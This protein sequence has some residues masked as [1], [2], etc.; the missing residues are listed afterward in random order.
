MGNRAV[1]RINVHEDKSK[2][3][4]VLLSDGPDGDNI[5]EVNCINEKHARDLIDMLGMNSFSIQPEF[6]NHYDA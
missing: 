3:F 5:I 6:Y 4:D 2:T 1:I